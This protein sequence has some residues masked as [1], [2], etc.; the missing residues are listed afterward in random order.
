MFSFDLVE[1][2]SMIYF[3]LFAPYSIQ[4][5][6]ELDELFIPIPAT[7]LLGIRRI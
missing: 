2:L 6:H 7:K 5:L 3:T 4:S 1:L